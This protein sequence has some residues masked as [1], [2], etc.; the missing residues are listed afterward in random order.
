MDQILPNEDDG[1]RNCIVEFRAGTGGDES[2]LFVGDLVRMYGYFCETNGWKSEIL[3]G[4]PIGKGWVYEL[5]MAVMGP[6]FMPNS[7]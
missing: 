5:T 3:R 6:M 2:A 1:D 4:Q 7:R